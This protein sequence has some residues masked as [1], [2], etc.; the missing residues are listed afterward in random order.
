MH[1]KNIH[2]NTVEKCKEC[3]FQTKRMYAM[4][5]HVQKV[6]TNI[7]LQTCEFC[8][9]LRKNLTKHLMRTM[10]GEGKTVVERRSEACEIC[11]KYFTLKESL[12]KHIRGV[13][14]KVKNRKCDQ[15]DYATYSGFN[16]KLHKSKMHRGEEIVKLNC[17]SCNV[18]VSNLPYHIKIYHQGSVK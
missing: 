12:K 2:E 6:H 4:K 3:D 13:H 5:R 14:N 11:G 17:P 9:V 8:G 1:V 18:D 7:N 10:C 15:C 16:L